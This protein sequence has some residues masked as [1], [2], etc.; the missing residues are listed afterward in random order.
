MK[1]CVN[2][3]FLF[4]PL[5][6]MA[7]SA[8][9]TLNGA[10]AAPAAD[11]KNTTQVQPAINVTATDQK[12]AG[13]P[14]PQSTFEERVKNL[15]V[16]LNAWFK[17]EPK[18][19]NDFVKTLDAS[20]K[21]YS[22]FDGLGVVDKQNALKKAILEAKPPIPVSPTDLEE[23]LTR[24]MKDKKFDTFNPFEF[25]KT[26]SKAKVTKIEPLNKKTSDVMEEAKKTVLKKYKDGMA[27]IEEDLKPLMEQ[28]QPLQKEMTDLRH[29]TKKNLKELGFPEKEIQRLMKEAA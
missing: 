20:F 29:E 23:L 2:L 25:Y 9:D 27:D 16:T 21:Q 15:R 22:F 24:Y 3:V 8:T 10:P 19:C 26:Y 18:K 5:F 4:Y 12:D 13:Y 7:D 1:I 11:Q 28:V 17:E 14:N 6:L